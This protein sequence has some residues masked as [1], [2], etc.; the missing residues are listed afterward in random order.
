MRRGRGG[1]RPSHSPIPF[2]RL[3]LVLVL[4]LFSGCDPFETEGCGDDVPEAPSGFDGLAA[5]TFIAEVSGDNRLGSSAELQGTARPF[6]DTVAAFTHIVMEAGNAQRRVAIDAL[7]LPEAQPGDV[8]PLRR[9]YYVQ[10]PDEP[11]EMNYAGPGSLRITA[12]TAERIE[13]SFAFCAEQSNALFFP[14]I[15]IRV[16]G[17]FHVVR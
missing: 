11:T 1:L 12:A 2:M 15:T 10:A 4:A 5:G 17:G 6:P 8:L 14:P 13:G 16:R 9:G 7:A 3:L